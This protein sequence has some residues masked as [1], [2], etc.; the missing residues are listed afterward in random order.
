LYQINFSLNKISKTSSINSSGV[1]SFPPSPV[2]HASVEPQKDAGAIYLQHGLYHIIFGSIPQVDFGELIY[3]EKLNKPFGIIL[4]R[5]A[6]KSS[7]LI[8]GLKF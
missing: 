7:A 4:L 6:P 1:I 3:K 2:S 5:V 8:C